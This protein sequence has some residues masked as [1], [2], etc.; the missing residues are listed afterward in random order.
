MLQGHQP[1]AAAVKALRDCY[2]HLHGGGAPGDLK[3]RIAS[4]QE[5]DK[6][7]NGEA[8]KRWQKEYLR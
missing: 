5:M 7:V 4:A 8:Y 2:A 6:L 3:D 1:V